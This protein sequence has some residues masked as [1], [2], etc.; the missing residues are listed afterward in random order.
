VLLKALKDERA[1]VRLAAAKNPNAT[2][3]FFE[4][5]ALDDDERVRKAV[6]HSD[7]ASMDAK[8]VAALEW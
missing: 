6:A 7:K 3:D 5:A 4:L 1:G 8:I 2:Y